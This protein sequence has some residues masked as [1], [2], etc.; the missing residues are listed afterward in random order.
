MT[1][2]E[3]QKRNNPPPP[4]KKKKKEGVG[5]DDS[6]AVLCTVTP[7]LTPKTIAKEYKDT[8]VQGYKDIYSP[9]T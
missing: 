4:K 1:G 8:R 9:M 5:V 3:K 6:F 2:R 7:F